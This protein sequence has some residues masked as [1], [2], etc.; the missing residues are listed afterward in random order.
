MSI[1]KKTP[2][3]RQKCFLKINIRTRSCFQ[4]YPSEQVKRIQSSSGKRSLLICCLCHP[5]TRVTR[6][7]W[8]SNR[9][10][11]VGC[12]GT[13]RSLHLP[14]SR[15]CTA[16]LNRK[17]SGRPGSGEQWWWPAARKV[18]P[19]KLQKWLG[20]S[21]ANPFVTSQ[22]EDVDLL[23]S[24]LE[25]IF[26]YPSQ[27]GI[28]G[29]ISQIWGKT[30]FGIVLKRKIVLQQIWNGKQLESVSLPNW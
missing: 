24:T 13:A 7:D 29:F 19:P 15:S 14:W 25:R 20:P 3:S 26:T 4:L 8:C 28:I 18:W 5:W 2:L 6:K 21:I 11:P 23:V 9:S 1:S 10:R 17:W 12:P 22:P 16:G 30:W 27:I